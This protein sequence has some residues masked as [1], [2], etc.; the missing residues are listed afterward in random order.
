M[1]TRPAALSQS[2]LTAGRR[3]DHAGFIAAAWQ[4]SI[5]AIIETGRR[6][7]DARKELAHGEF[8]AMIKNDLPFGEDTAERLI[9][10]ARDPRLSNSAHGR[11]LPPS[12]R[13]LFE[14]T[15]LNDEQFDRLVAAGV[16]RADMHRWE[17][18]GL[19][20]VDYTPSP[21][22]RLSSNAS[23]N[24][25][26]R[27]E[28][29]NTAS[30]LNPASHDPTRATAVLSALR[31]VVN[32]GNTEMVGVAIDS[33]PDLGGEFKRLLDRVLSMLSGL[34]SRYGGATQFPPAR[35]QEV[36]ASA[37]ASASPAERR[38][39]IGT[40]GSGAIWDEMTAEQRTALLDY[41][42]GQGAVQEAPNTP[43]R[44]GASVY[45]DQTEGTP[46]NE[47]PGVPQFCNG[48]ESRPTSAWSV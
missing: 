46:P 21:A 40:V 26:A 27:L 42:R 18:E 30:R 23:K 3:H 35:S 47:M 38:A 24:A 22:T 12:W 11:I 41:G 32:L 4:K 36:L 29:K 20:S 19:A 10:I 5:E 45:I 44:P 34:R 6:L 39:F 13:T 1:S 43:T 48:R 17:I 25:L 2:T 31:A 28:N 14:L 9:K 15:K 8:L 7:I 16:I 37:W 33:A